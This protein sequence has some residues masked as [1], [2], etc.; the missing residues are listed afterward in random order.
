MNILTLPIREVATVDPPVRDTP[1]VEISARE[2]ND[3][4]SGIQ[5]LTR[6]ESDDAV[7][8]TADDGLGCMRGLFMTM[9]LYVGV[10]TLSAL[11]WGMWRLLR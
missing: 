3:A 8:A 4:L 2:M 9:F 7:F 11:A 10:L 5:W 6:I 1:G